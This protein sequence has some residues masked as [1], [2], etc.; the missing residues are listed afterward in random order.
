[1]RSESRIFFLP[2]N[3]PF[4]LAFASPAFTRSAIKSLSNCDIAARIENKANPTA[5]ILSGAMMLRHLGYPVEATALETAVRGVIAEGRTI[6]YD[7]GGT[8]GTAAF[9]DAVIGRLGT[10]AAI[11]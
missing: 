3:L 11:A 1:M 8:A 4:A 7:L 9:A 10:P 6:T 5:L 2:I